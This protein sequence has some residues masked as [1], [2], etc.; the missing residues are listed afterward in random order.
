[1]LVAR[2]KVI[3]DELREHIPG[4]AAAVLGA[5]GAPA[6]YHEAPNQSFDYAVLEK[7]GRVAVVEAAFSWSDVGSWAS[8]AEEAREGGEENAHNSDANVI[9]LSARD[10]A[11]WSE[12]TVVL[13]DVS[14]LVVVDTS[15]VLY[16]TRKASVGKIGEARKAA[17]AAN[18]SLH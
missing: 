12:K 5:V 9:A 11:V 4:M 3:F 17:L 16:V 15:E 14:D 10:N 18:P 1:L 8:W 13:Q 6:R 7:S 2:P